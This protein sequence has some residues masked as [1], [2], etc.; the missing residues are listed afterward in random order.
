MQ[1]W[2]EW[3]MQGWVCRCSGGPRQAEV[4][5][6][7]PYEDKQREMPSPAPGVELQ[8]APVQHQAPA[9]VEGWP[10]GKQLCRKCP[11]GHLVG[12]K[13]A[14]WSCSKA[15]QHLGLHRAEQHLQ[16]KRNDPSMDLLNQHQ[17]VMGMLERASKVPRDDWGAGVRFR[18]GEIERAGSAQHGE[19]KALGSYQRIGW[20][21]GVTESD[22]SQC[23]SAKAQQAMGTKWNTGSLN[24]KT[25]FLKEQSSTGYPE[26]LWD[27]HHGR[28]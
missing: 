20:W 17:R 9:Q 14:T 15:Q 2:E 4:T 10:V 6:Q 21:E 23:I 19:G 5:L 12:H 26:I 16:G 18:W 27:I 7:D 22:S 1:N 3:L 11:R 25:F 28:C 24:I 8:Q 13:A